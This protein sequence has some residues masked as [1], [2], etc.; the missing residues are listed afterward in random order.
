MEMKYA[1]L[2]WYCLLCFLGLAQED[3]NFEVLA[4]GF[5]TSDMNQWADHF[6]ELKQEKINLNFCT[7]D[8]LRASQ[9][10]NIFQI[11]NLI[12]YRE[13]SGKIY[14]LAELK[15]VKGFSFE[16]IET[17]KPY[18]DL[19]P[20]NPKPKIY[21]IWDKN[22]SQHEI[23]WRWSRDVNERRAYAEKH[24]LGDA[25][26]SNLRYRY[27]NGR[28]LRMGLNLQK[29][30]GEP[31]KSPS[32][33]LGHDH[34][35]F[36]LQ[37]KRLGRIEKII[38]GDFRYEFGQGLCLQ[39]GSIGSTISSS[40]LKL[41]PKGA[42]AYAG[43]D[44]NHFFRGTALSLKIKDAWR[45]SSFLSI[46]KQD[47][48]IDS[49]L[50]A[51]DYTTVASGLHRTPAEFEQ[52][53]LFLRKSWG[54]DFQF[55]TQ[56][57]QWGLLFFNETLSSPIQE[58][59][60]ESL[61]KH[62]HALSLHWNYLKRGFNFFGE[63]SNPTSLNPRDCSFLTGFQMPWTPQIN[64]A[65]S[66]FSLS[67]SEISAWAGNPHLAK[68]VSGEQGFKLN[69]SGAWNSTQQS[70]LQAQFSQFSSP[71]FLNEGPGT[72]TNL[73]IN[74][75]IIG[76]SWSLQFNSQYRHERFQQAEPEKLELR[77][78]NDYK[79]LTQLQ[80]QKFLNRYFSLKARLSFSQSRKGSS[81]RIKGYLTN[82]ALEIS[83]ASIKLKTG[84]AFSKVGHWDSRIY[85]F[86]PDFPFSF[87]IPAFGGHALRNYLLI[88]FPITSLAQVHLKS[89]IWHYFDRNTI[90]SGWQE[91]TGP[92][93]LNLKFALRIKI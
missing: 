92:K 61:E 53:N 89:S 63:I 11:N 22:F 38:A 55:E 52:K 2:I 70:I 29:D 28:H 32:N 42:K 81:T 80:L 35:S 17:L 21:P 30:P 7:V 76:N 31:W 65:I 93:H 45:V 3:L 25:W 19:N 33:F 71:T 5:N 91:I 44:E 74:H 64:A 90:S 43:S 67:N 27:Q 41:Y 87:S 1:H 13:R 82:I 59:A 84:F 75:K 26:D 58:L 23:I 18:L 54:F 79:S 47:G 20:R 34:S 14:S 88:Q 8:E 73:S 60:E 78:S 9:L 51:Y 6:E 62:N 77:P 83:K 12:Q 24:Y 36:Y 68:N 16:I 49:N 86:E 15:Q 66:F 40:D 56:S 37:L 4:N 72:Q 46:K 39:S 50:W 69:L 48:R 85:L 10:L 57:W